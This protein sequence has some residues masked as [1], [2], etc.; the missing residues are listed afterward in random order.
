LR[1]ESTVRATKVPS[2]PRA[3][4]TGLNGW[5]TEPIGVEQ[6]LG[7]GDPAPHPDGGEI[8]TAGMLVP[9]APTLVHELVDAPSLKELRL[10]PDR[11]RLRQLVQGDVGRDV[12]GSRIG[13]IV[14]APLVAAV[15]P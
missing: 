8:G 14:A 12:L 4:E 13:E 2:A 15:G 7:L 3:R 11:V 9:V 10:R 1:S 6:R 5:S